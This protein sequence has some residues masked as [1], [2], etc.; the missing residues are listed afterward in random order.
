M[1]KLLSDAG[2]AVRRGAAFGVAGLVKGYGLGA[3]KQF[4]IM[5]KLI[6]AASS[7]VSERKQSAMFAFECLSGALG[8][9][10]EPYVVHVLPLLLSTLGDKTAAVRESAEMAADAIV[11]DGYALSSGG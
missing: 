7:N 5:N 6:E 11:C 4:E 3:L 9:L 10:F 8:R 1:N 2:F